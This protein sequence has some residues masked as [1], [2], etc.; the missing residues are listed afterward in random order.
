MERHHVF[1]LT[2]LA[3]TVYLFVVRLLRYQRRDSIPRTYG[4]VDRSDFPKMSADKAQAILSDLI[5]I[6]F[7]TLWRQSIIFAIFKT[8][9]IPTI[10]QLLANTSE[11]QGTETASKRVA[12]TGVLIKEMT[13]NPSSSPRTLQAIARM[14]YLHSRYIKAGKISNDD[15]VYTLGL[16]ALE[17]TRWIGKYEWRQLTDVELCALGTFWK[18]VGDKM[19]ID[20]SPLPSASEGWQDG[21][22]WLTE[23]RV[24][25]EKYE[26]NH[27]IA[28]EPNAKLTRAL[29]D[30]LFDGMPQSIKS[31]GTL[32]VAAVV[33]E[34]LRIATML[35]TPPQVYVIGFQ[36][37]MYLRKLVLR[38]LLLPRPEFLRVVNISR[39]P[40]PSGRYT[41]EEWL[42]HPWYVKATLWRRWGPNAWIGRLQGSKLPG[43]D[44]EKY[45]PQGYLI[46][47]VGPKRTE[48]Q[49]GVEMRAD[50]DKMHA[51]FG[52]CPFAM[53]LKA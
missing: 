24:W 21:L 10:A 39:K 47:E 17:P 51:R 8:Y 25:G 14:N 30:I 3:V 34:R 48:K 29:V 50:V 49:G 31:I 44:G 13:L 16:F 6:E 40:E 23:M 36:T 33:P 37:I 41:N 38:Y 27:M 1:L 2:S 22:H 4:M 46:A 9:G 18:D 42:T 52:S 7:P 19:E 35:P 11:L 32:V 20:Y 26:E 43:D 53:S 15:M 45:Y 12:D 28:A 5:E